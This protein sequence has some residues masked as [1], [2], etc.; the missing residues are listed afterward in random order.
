MG[1]IAFAIAGACPWGRFREVTLTARRTFPRG[2]IARSAVVPF[3]MMRPLVLVVLFALGC[4]RDGA[5]PAA[6]GPQQAPQNESECRACKGEWGIHGLAQVVSCL[7]RAHDAGKTCKDGLECEGECEVVDGKEQ[8]TAAGPPRRGYFVG[9]CT[10]YE[11][12]FG[13]H[14]LLMDGTAAKGPVNLDDAL[15]EICID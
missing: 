2:N 12:I 5:R 8:V 6:A 1:A 10:E 7:C 11:H 13:C 3:D 9:R 15:A 4:H 14:R